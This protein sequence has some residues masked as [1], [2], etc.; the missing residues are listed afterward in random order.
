MKI[1]IGAFI[2]V[3]V[4]FGLVHFGD[5]VFC[6]AF[7]PVAEGREGRV[8]AKRVDPWVQSQVDRQQWALDRGF[9]SP[10]AMEFQLTWQLYAHGDTRGEIS[11][12]EA[13]Q[14]VRG[15]MNSMGIP[16]SVQAEKEE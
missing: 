3:V 11:Q 13:L 15:F 9:K 7:P 16:P 8:V 14:K 4:F 5:Q 2:L 12:K 10:E 6:T 1:W